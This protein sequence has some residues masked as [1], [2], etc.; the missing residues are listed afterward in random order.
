MRRPRYKPRKPSAL[1]L[2]IIKEGTRIILL[3]ALLH[4]LLIL[5]VIGAGLLAWLAYDLST[6]IITGFAVYFFGQFLSLFILECIVA[7]SDESS[8]EPHH[9]TDAE[10]LAAL[11]AEL[12]STP[13]N[14]QP[15]T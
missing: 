6:G 15:H 1:L 3:A 11:K 4:L 8:L 2:D 14:T 7:P 5:S 10:V 9:P 13:E 12:Q